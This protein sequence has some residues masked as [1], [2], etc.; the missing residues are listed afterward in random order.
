MQTYRMET[1]V[2]NDGTI[3]I[4]GLP[5]HVGDKVEVIVRSR[6]HEFERRERYPLR[7]KPIRY[8]DAFGSV[9]EDEWEVLQ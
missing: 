3:T 7:D 1:T 9:A 5:F 8:V 6:E 4:N 2:L